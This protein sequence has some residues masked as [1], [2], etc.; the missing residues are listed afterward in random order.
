MR[1]YKITDVNDRTYAG[2]QW[3]EGRMHKTDGKGG[4]CSPGFI[5]FY[6]D[7]R[8]AVLLNPIHGNYQPFH[9][10]LGEAG[11]KIEEDNGLKWGCTEFK[12]IK[13]VCIPRITLT[14]KVAFAILCSLE[15]YIDPEYKKWAE[16]WLQNKDRMAVRVTREAAKAA[17]AAEAARKAE[18]A[19]AAEAA[20]WAA[21]AAKAAWEAETAW[22][23]KAATWAT[24]A[25]AWAT[26][27]AA[28]AAK[29]A[30]A[31]RE[32]EAA[33]AAAR[34]ARTAGINLVR[35]AK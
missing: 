21:K 14:Q 19:K 35:L 15:V 29:I 3:H 1:A 13:R 32:A 7:K 11:G 6:R 8:L 17:E 22:A 34:V 16:A 2:F 18:T 12:M 20:I 28:W 9:L 24:G 4:L 26:G 31:A 23:V 10:W 5:H 30:E 33:W 27:A 25:A